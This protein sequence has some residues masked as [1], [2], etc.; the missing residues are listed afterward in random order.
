MWYPREYHIRTKLLPIPIAPGALDR[1][2]T[3]E[4]KPRRLHP[5]WSDPALLKRAKVDQR[6]KLD[7]MAS[8]FQAGLATRPRLEPGVGYQSHGGGFGPGF[9]SDPLVDLE[10]SGQCLPLGVGSAAGPPPGIGSPAGPGFQAGP[11]PGNGSPAGPGFQGGPEQDEGFEKRLKRKAKARELD[12]QV[13]SGIDQLRRMLRQGV[14]QGFVPGQGYEGTTNTRANFSKLKLITSSIAVDSLQ[15]HL[16]HA[17]QRLQST[18]TDRVHSETE[19]YHQEAVAERRRVDAMHHDIKEEIKRGGDREVALIHECEMLNQKTKALQEED[20]QAMLESKNLL[21]SLKNVES[22]RSTTM[23]QRLKKEQDATSKVEALL[24]VQQLELSESRD[25]IA[26]LKAEL[27][28]T[29]KLESVEVEECRQKSEEQTRQKLL[30]EE[31]V[32]ATLQSDISDVRMTEE[33]AAKDA[34]NIKGLVQDLLVERWD[35]MKP[36]VPP[37]CVIPSAASRSGLKYLE[38]QERVWQDASV[39]QLR[40]AKLEAEALLRDLCDNQLTTVASELH[41]AYVENQM[42]K[43]D[44]GRQAQILGEQAALNGVL[45]VEF[46][47]AT[48]VKEREVAFYEEETRSCAVKQMQQMVRCVLSTSRKMSE[49]NKMWRETHKLQE[50][51]A[52]SRARSEKLEA[53]ADEGQNKL[54]MLDEQIATLE[55]QSEAARSLTGDFKEREELMKSLQQ[56]QAYMDR[57]SNRLAAGTSS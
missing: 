17:F 3:P 9:T 19:E 53:F 6:G 16:Q 4:V 11:P 31:Q 54:H 44:L 10:G 13:A 15:D 56:T 32:I 2:G 7:P 40:S 47:E 38:R 5:S 29:E 22:Q 27:E 35:E 14:K 30:P 45:G 49:S 50:Q 24:S 37:H 51:I 12:D 26:E 39:R 8:T 34:E 1:A 41:A 25:E 28:R 55:A 33:A 43:E 48:A 18:V 20:Q 23:N 36:R 21:L 42:I 52:A 46:D 57:M